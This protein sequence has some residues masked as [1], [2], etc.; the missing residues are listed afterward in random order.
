MPDTIIAQLLNNQELDT[1][2][3]DFYV[4]F[5]RQQNLNVFS[6]PALWVTKCL[7]NTK[8][9][10]LKSLKGFA[11]SKAIKMPWKYS[12]LHSFRELMLKY[13]HNMQGLKVSTI[14]LRR[15][16]IAEFG[17]III[18]AFKDKQ[19]TVFLFPISDKILKNQNHWYLMVVYVTKH[20][21][22]QIVV[23][24]S[25]WRL[26]SQRQKDWDKIVAR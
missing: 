12:I 15:R 25:H 9:Q 23:W 26:L 22:I 13:K 5:L 10:N 7:L 20:K 2:F 6:F 4:T 18:F 19:H 3:L 1:S 21:K 14:L 17:R 16:R 24:N 8:C 11:F